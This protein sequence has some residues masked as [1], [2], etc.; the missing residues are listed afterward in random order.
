M[1]CDDQE[2]CD[3]AGVEGRFKREGGSLY[4]WLIHFTVQQN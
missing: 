3:G 4:I 2:G 1:L